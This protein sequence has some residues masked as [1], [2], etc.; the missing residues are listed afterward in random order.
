MGDWKAER[1]CAHCGKAFMPKVGNQKNCEECIATR[2]GRPVENRM[3]EWKAEKPCLRCGNAFT[4]KVGNQKNCQE[5]IAARPPRRERQ[6]VLQ[7]VLDG[8]EEKLKR[9]T[10]RGLCQRHQVKDTY[11][12][13]RY[14]F[15]GKPLNIHIAKFLFDGQ[16]GKCGLCHKSLGRF[17]EKGEARL[18]HDHVT[19]EARGWLCETCNF[20]EGLELH[21]WGSIG[22]SMIAK[23]S[24][25]EFRVWMGKLKTWRLFGLGRTLTPDD[26]AT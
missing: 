8:C 1:Q 4:P 9:A 18:D 12:R 5:C 21:G 25:R 13:S 26:F 10:K 7:C 20:M 19:G 24:E 14:L 16:G 6:P 3:A 17:G 22:L 23:M 11:Y 15:Y 2:D